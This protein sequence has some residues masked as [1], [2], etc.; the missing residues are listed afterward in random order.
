MEALGRRLPLSAYFP[1]AITPRSTHPMATAAT[2]ERADAWS[3]RDDSKVTATSYEKLDQLWQSARGEVA[4]ICFYKRVWFHG[5]ER[6]RE[7][8]EEVKEPEC[9]DLVELVAADQRKQERAKEARLQK[10][11]AEEE[12]RRVA[13]AAGSL[14]RSARVKAPKLAPPPKQPQKLTFTDTGDTHELAISAVVTVLHLRR[15]LHR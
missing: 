6:Q 7:V 15:L 1:A 10:R 11:K 12:N 9:A 2:S 14:R 8:A 13:E 5:K 3:R 4:Q